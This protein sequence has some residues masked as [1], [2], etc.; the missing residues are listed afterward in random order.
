ME[1]LRLYICVCACVSVSVSVCV[2]VCLCL[3]LCLCVAVC[4]S[5]CLYLCVS[6]FTSVSV[7]V[8]VCVSTLQTYIF[9]LCATLCRP[10]P[11]SIVGTMRSLH[12]VLV[13]HER[14]IIALSF[15]NYADTPTYSMGNRWIL[16]LAWE[17]WDGTSYLSCTHLS[18]VMVQKM[19]FLIISVLNKV[20]QEGRKWQ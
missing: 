1:Y 8:P 13:V 10:K 4:V 2:Y 7:S 14:C 6:V 15:Y 12:R 17:G 16:L 3:C 5:V 19:G 11:I 9:L 18:S 20:T